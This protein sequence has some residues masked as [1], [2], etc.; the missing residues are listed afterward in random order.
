[1]KEPSIHL[2]RDLYFSYTQFFVYDSSVQMP[3]CDWTKGHS[4]QGFARRE[5]TVAFG[6]L[7]EFGKAKVVVHLAPYQSRGE[8]QRVIAVPFEATTGK[9]I[10]HGPE[11]T[12]TGRERNFALPPGNYRLVAA[13]RVTGDEEEAIDLFFEPL[14]KTL[15]RSAVLVADDALHPSSPLLEGAGVAGEE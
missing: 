15:E 14:R 10:V 8:H 6:T 5:G 13:Q 7:L 9:V 2:V 11:E 12:E 1:M 3:A 4:D